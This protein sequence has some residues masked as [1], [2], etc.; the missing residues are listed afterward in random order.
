MAHV[1]FLRRRCNVTAT[2][3]DRPSP[4][5]RTTGLQHSSFSFLVSYPRPPDQERPRPERLRL[6]V[7]GIARSRVVGRMRTSGINEQTAQSST[8]HSGVGCQAGPF[9]TGRRAG[10]S[11][12]TG[13]P[14]PRHPN[15]RS[16][17]SFPTFLSEKP[18]GRSPRFSASSSFATSRTSDAGASPASTTRRTLPGSRRGKPRGRRLDAP[19]LF[20][21]AARRARCSVARPLFVANASPDGVTATA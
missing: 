5:A 14:P 8:W 6:G 20:C 15:V 19:S 17:R 11:A 2:T 21:V 1:H 4:Q 18:R 10:R 16:F 13:R 9:A 7:S 3:E 12:A